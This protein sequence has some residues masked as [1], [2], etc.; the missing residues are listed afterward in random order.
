MTFL[1]LCEGAARTDARRARQ[2]VRHNRHDASPS[3]GHCGRFLCVFMCVRGACVC[4]CVGMRACMY[5]CM[6]VCVCVC[7]RAC[8]C[9]RVRVTV[10]Q[11]ICGTRTLEQRAFVGDGDQ[12]VGV[13]VRFQRQGQQR[14]QDAV[15]NEGQ[16][17]LGDG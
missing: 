5:V 3:H 12:H 6:Y 11:A 13:R 10:M 17:S 9:V 2:H 4:T 1:P 16:D 8:V 15:L 14:H 7:A